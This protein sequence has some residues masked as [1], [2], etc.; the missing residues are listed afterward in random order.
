M[1]DKLS[2][3]GV[4]S[5][6]IVSNLRSFLWIP[7]SQ[8]AEK[9]ISL[10][11]FGHMLYLD[12]SFHLERKTGALSSCYLRDCLSAYLRPEVAGR[13]GRLSALRSC[14]WCMVLCA[15]MVV[16]CEDAPMFC[17]MW[18]GMRTA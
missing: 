1:V 10:R 14:C 16:L 4:G 17:R 8:D 18:R 12:L 11:A 15:A 7:I 6:G 13:A 9:R 2:A 3:G 5:V